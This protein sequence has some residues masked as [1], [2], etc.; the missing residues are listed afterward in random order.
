VGRALIYLF[1]LAVVCLI[2]FPYFYMLSMGLM[3]DG[4]S[5]AIPA[6]L[7]P[8]TFQWHNYAIAFA[9]IQGLRTYVNTLIVAVG[10][11]G[12]QLFTSSLAGF[13]FAKYSFRGRELLFMAV[14]ATMTIPLFINIIPWFWMIQRMGIDNQ[15]AGVMFPSL[16]SAYG[17]FLMRQFMVDLPD[18]LADAAR[19]D[20]ASEFCIY[21]RI[22]LPLCPPALVTLGAF[23]FLYHWNDLLWPLIVLKDRPR[24]IINLMVTSLQGYGGTGRH[25]EIAAA[26]M[27]VIPVL[28][29]VIVLQ[30]Y[31]VQTVATTGLKG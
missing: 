17:I 22:V 2:S 15:L 19:I 18:E 3:T 4:E 16:V 24:W 28:L 7:L 9:R 23:I 13:G 6:R 1:L 27:A 29:L 25:L 12:V 20:G 14:L 21:H 26:S 11:A 5:V 8:R 30:R 10:V 31:V